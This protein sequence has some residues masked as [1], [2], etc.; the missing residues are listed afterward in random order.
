MARNAEN[1]LVGVIMGS[2]SD[3]PHIRKIGKTFD[4]LEVP[5]EFRIKSAH[6]TPEA[7]MEYARTARKRGLKAII[8]AA[9]GSAHLPGMVA[10]ETILPVLGVA[11]ESSPD[12][13]NAAIGSMIR[14]PEGIPLATMGKSSEKSQGGAVNAALFAARILANNDE[15]LFRRLEDHQ[16]KLKTGVIEKDE[17]L[18]TADIDDYI[19][20]RLGK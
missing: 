19:T 17:D 10:S 3:L 6:R 2:D 20:R 1:P 13:L 5:Y 7:M 11:V 8:A 18:A 16:D 15:D 9:G 4:D 12:P 14:M